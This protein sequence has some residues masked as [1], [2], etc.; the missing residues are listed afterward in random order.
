[1]KSIIINTP[2][3][4]CT[5][6]YDG[7]ELQLSRNMS[8]IHIP[9]AGIEQIRQL[10]ESSQDGQ[11]IAAP[12]IASPVI[13]LLEEW[14]GL[15]QVSITSSSKEEWHTWHKDLA[16]RTQ[17]FINGPVKELNEAELAGLAAEMKKALPALSDDE[18]REVAEHA[19]QYW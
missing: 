6:S 11:P 16:A 13:A 4:D 5:A 18:A 8:T 14:A 19:R 1:M 12:P 2:Y 15:A 10:V 17:T 3:G 9:A 7:Q